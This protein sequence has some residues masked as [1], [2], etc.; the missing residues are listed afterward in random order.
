MNARGASPAYS[1]CVNVIA[2]AVSGDIGISSVR[3]VSAA[4]TTARRPHAFLSLVN[5]LMPGPGDQTHTLGRDALSA[6]SPSVAAELS[7]VTVASSSQI[8]DALVR[9]M[10]Q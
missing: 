8:A 1:A 6:E 7:A 2:S 3:V 4:S 5:L 10:L 9:S